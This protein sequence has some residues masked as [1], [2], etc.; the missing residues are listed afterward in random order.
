M[1]EFAAMR[2]AAYHQYVKSV[3]DAKWSLD[4]TRSFLDD[5]DARLASMRDDTA[6]LVRSTQGAVLTMYHWAGHPCGRVTGKSRSLSSFDRTLEGE[7]R[8]RDLSRC[9]ACAWPSP[10]SVSE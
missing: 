1:T 10:A 4:W 3:E 9:P 6:V 2:I 5:E 7:A 8:R